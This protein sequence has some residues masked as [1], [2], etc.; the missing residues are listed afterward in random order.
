M[1]S[2]TLLAALNLP[3]DLPCA[4]NLTALSMHLAT[5][6]DYRKKRGIR[7]PLVPMLLVALLAKLAG[8]SRLAD[9]AEWA[10]LRAPELTSL[11]GL[12][13]AT[14]PH[15][16]TWSRLLAHAID[17]LALTQHLRTFFATAYQTNL[18]PACGSLVVAVDG[19]T[20]RGTIPAGHTHGVHLVAAYHPA[21]GVVLAQVA[22]DQK[23]NEIVA[24]PTVVAALDLQG[25]VVV[26]DAMQT[27]RGLSIQIV[28]GGGD[29]LWMVKEN[30]K[31]LL[32]DLEQLFRPLAP[33]PGTSDEPTDFTT[34]RTVSKG[35]GRMEERTITV[36]SMLEEYSDWPYLAQ[37]FKLERRVQRR[38]DGQWGKV[39][40]EV[41]YGVTSLPA[42][43]ASAKR[44]LVIARAEWGIENSLHYRRDVTLREDASTFRRGQGPQVTAAL[45]NAVIGLALQHQYHNLASLQRQF[46]YAFDRLLAKNAFCPCS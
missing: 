4:I 11:L 7:Y 34:A 19:K 1:D 10:Q 29:Y 12:D 16:S 9:I 2:T 5:L 37:V 35:H 20:L 43:V 39:T 22:V 26:G 3:L 41:R 44:L 15:P 13:R 28:E 45:N 18:V 31:T 40:T 14:M 38:V 36:S 25:V 27:Q 30:Q 8:Y 32:A 33:L 17:P 23:A 21:T 46:A 42:R 6:V 24:M